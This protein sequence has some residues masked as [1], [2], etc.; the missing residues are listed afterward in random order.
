VNA[1][2]IRRVSMS[3]LPTSE[4]VEDVRPAGVEHDFRLP[5]S[6]IV[7]VL[8]ECGQSSCT[9][10]IVLSVSA[11]ETIRR[12]PTRFLIKEGHEVSEF[13][14]VVDYGM[15]YVVVAKDRCE[16]LPPGGLQ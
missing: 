13:D 15:G 7:E 6:Q 10:R 14:R 1:I 11:Y 3:A 8:C 5:P 16:S 12:S 2:S 9:G 4:Y